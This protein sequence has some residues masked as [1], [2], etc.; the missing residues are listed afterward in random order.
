MNRNLTLVQCKIGLNKGESIDMEN[1][2]KSL[3]VLSFFTMNIPVGS[4]D[5]SSGP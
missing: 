3:Y 2:R 4:S 5:C 1:E